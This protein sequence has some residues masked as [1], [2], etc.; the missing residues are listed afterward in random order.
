MCRRLPYLLFRLVSALGRQVH[1]HYPCNGHYARSCRFAGPCL[2]AESVETLTE[3][4]SFCKH[5]GVFLLVS[6]TTRE[7]R[8]WLAPHSS[9]ECLTLMQVPAISALI[10]SL[11]VAMMGAPQAAELLSMLVSCAATGFVGGTMRR[12]FRAKYG[13]PVG[14]C[15]DYIVYMLCEPVRRC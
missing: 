1:E 13:L 14:P 10:V 4:G 11:P 15:N 6:A 12:R 3:N 2:W 7:A 5:L 9:P 8:P